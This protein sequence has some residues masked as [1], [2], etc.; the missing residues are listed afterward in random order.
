MPTYQLICCHVLLFIDLFYWLQ[1]QIW[2]IQNGQK[3]IVSKSLQ[4]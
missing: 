1:R 2:N 4:Y 3:I